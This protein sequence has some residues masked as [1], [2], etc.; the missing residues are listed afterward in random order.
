[1]MDEIQ[2]ERARELVGELESAGLN[3]GLLAVEGIVVLRGPG[4]PY[5][6]TPTMFNERDL[7][8]AI[9]LGLLEK[10]KVTGSYE[11]EWF[12]TKKIK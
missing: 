3:S 1:M 6:E 4:A 12:V 8:N 10:R 7:D 5:T 11:W 9:A 2:E